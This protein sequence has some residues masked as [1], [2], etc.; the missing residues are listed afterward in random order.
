[1]HKH[2]FAVLALAMVA[3]TVSS[4]R[5]AARDVPGAV[6]ADAVAYHGAMELYRTL[7]VY[8]GKKA[9]AAELRYREVI[10]HG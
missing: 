10:D 6:P 3:A 8:F 9:M 1:M 7:A 5:R 2:V 4:A